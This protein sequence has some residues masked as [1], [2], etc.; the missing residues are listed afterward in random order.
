[1]PVAVHPA[2]P[3]SSV[4]SR[5]YRERQVRRS[6]AAVVA[7]SA[8]LTIIPEEKNSSDFSVQFLGAG[9]FIYVLRSTS[10]VFLAGY[11]APYQPPNQ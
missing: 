3:E 6:E 8:R 9:R 2:N 1:L 7:S 4:E 5:R 10:F 11:S